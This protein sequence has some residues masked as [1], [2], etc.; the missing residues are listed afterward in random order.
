MKFD[1]IDLNLRIQYV[2]NDADIES[3]IAFGR[4]I[5]QAVNKE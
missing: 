2:P 1:I 3:C 4:Q 5:G